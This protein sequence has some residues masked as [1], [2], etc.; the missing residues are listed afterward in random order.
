VKGSLL[1]LGAVLAACQPQPDRVFVPGTPFKHE[2]RVATDQG[3]TARLRVGDWLPLHATRETGPWVAVERTSLGKDGCWVAPP[4]PA[5]EEEVAAE[6]HWT[7]RP[8]GKAEFDSGL[9]E[10]HTR[11]VRFSAP[12][13]YVIGASSAT[14][15]SPKV[16]ANELAVEVV[17]ESDP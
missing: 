6:L 14:W 2:V 8:A 5:R 9:S 10:D 7:A 13:R 12:G 4:P 15:C 11:R 1:G 16:T 3:F 17:G